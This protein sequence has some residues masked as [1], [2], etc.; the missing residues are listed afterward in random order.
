MSLHRFAA[1]RDANEPA[2]RER[3]SH[4]GWH[5]EQISGKGM[6]DL[7][8]FPTVASKGGWRLAVLV[9][10]KMPKGTLK[11]AQVE[12]WTALAQK[13]IP[14]Y[15]ARS[16][17]DVDAIVA[18]EAEPWGVLED[19]P[20]KQPRASQPTV[21]IPTVRVLDKQRLHKGSTTAGRSYKPQSAHYPPGKAQASRSEGLEAFG[22]EVKR[23]I[24]IKAAQMAGETFA[25]PPPP[26]HT[27]CAEADRTDG[28]QHSGQCEHDTGSVVGMVDEP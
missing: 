12:K 9:D 1:A 10:V 22:A 15:V 20:K 16:E 24:G 3:F 6:P 5:T 19:A 18:G 25:P 26:V 7:L 14:V 27:C 17:V 28:R 2:I 8:C 4:H 13:G 23:R 11:P 21:I